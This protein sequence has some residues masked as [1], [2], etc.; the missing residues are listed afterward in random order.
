MTHLGSIIAAYAAAAGVFVVLTGWV[1]LDGR[2]Q[3]RKLD[4]LGEAGRA[5]FSP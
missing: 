4:R 3:R 2:R 1:V 5:R